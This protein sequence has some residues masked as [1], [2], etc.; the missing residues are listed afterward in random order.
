MVTAFPFPEH[1][2][3]CFISVSTIAVEGN[4]QPGMTMYPDVSQGRLGHLYIDDMLRV[5]AL[6]RTHWSEMAGAGCAASQ[7]CPVFEWF[8]GIAQW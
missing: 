8:A 1:G 2:Y 5:V 7:I 6:A 3:A 4:R